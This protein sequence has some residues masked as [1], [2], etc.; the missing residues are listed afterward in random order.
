M[1]YCRLEGGA[2]KLPATLADLIASIDQAGA[3]LF[4]E[5]DDHGNVQGV[6]S[7]GDIRRAILSG[8]KL[9]DHPGFIVNRSPRIK[10]IARDSEMQAVSVSQLP[11]S[12]TILVD[13][14]NRFLGVTAETPDAPV[15]SETCVLLAGGKGVRLRPLTIETPKP[16]LEVAGKPMMESLLLQLRSQGFRKFVVSV[17]YLAEQIEAHFGDGSKFGVSI[18]YLHETEPLGT[19]G[20]LADLVVRSEESVLVVNAD[21]RTSLVFA[22]LLDGHLASGADVTVAV[23]VI[24]QQVPFGVVEAIAGRITEIVEKPKYSHF[25]SCGIYALRGSALAPLVSGRPKDMPDL[26]NELI[27]LNRNVSAFPVIEPWLDLGTADNLKS[28]ESFPV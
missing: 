18:E 7:D 26:L 6:A 2:G 28:A 23:K 27:Q 21:V 17:N 4:V 11:R 24:E 9:D 1:K 8:A 10:I 16:M 3:G 15:R 20:P 5:V 19:A 22:S 14:E 12:T 25:V 13:E